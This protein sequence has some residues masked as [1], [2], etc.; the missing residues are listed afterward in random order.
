MVNPGGVGGAVDRDRTVGLR[1][2]LGNGPPTTTIS[3]D[4]VRE[5]AGAHTTGTT[6]ATYGAF[7][8]DA[9]AYHALYTVDQ[10]LGSSSSPGSFTGA[11]RIE[12][13]RAGGESFA[14]TVDQAFVASSATDYPLDYQ[15]ADWAYYTLYAL[16]QQPF[17]S[18][19]LT[20]VSLTGTVDADGS[21]WRRPAL[22]VRQHGVWVRP[23]HRQL[24]VAAGRALRWQ[25]TA[26]LF[27]RPDVTQTR[28]AAVV[29]PARFAGK[30]ATVVVSAGSGEDFFFFEPSAS[31]FT[32]LLR[33]LA[34]QPR[35]DELRV[36]LRLPRT[37]RVLDTGTA[38]FDRVIRPRRAAFQVQLR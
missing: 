12:G 11:L 22:R 19:H 26:P 20:S 25:A 31:S 14:V 37:G 38:L 34:A 9:A 16:L 10:A 3:S 15:V 32:G 2:V 5:P 28:R 23:Q 29:A 30:R 27:Q 18:V 7:T 6:Y 21:Y 17:E 8:P 1:A 35:G 13:T 33:E 24:S 36:E 4:V